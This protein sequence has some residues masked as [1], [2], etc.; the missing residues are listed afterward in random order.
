[1]LL[2]WRSPSLCGDLLEVCPDIGAGFVTTETTMGFA[3]RVLGK[4][5]CASYFNNCRDIHHSKKSQLFKK[6]KI[7]ITGFMLITILV[8]SA[9]L[10]LLTQN[11]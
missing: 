2:R 11:C 6:N 9:T 10:C 7:E 1:M 3:P 8:I 5:R 4:N